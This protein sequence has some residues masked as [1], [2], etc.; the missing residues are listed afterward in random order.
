MAAPAPIG[1]V[2]PT[3]QHAGTVGRAVR[4]ALDGGGPPVRVVV[5]DDGSSDDTAAVLAA[6]DD[7]RLAVHRQANRGRGAARNRGASLCDTAALL[8]LDSD[9]ELLPGA[10]SELTGLLEEPDVELA[11]GA[12]LVERVPSDPPAV[13]PSSREV[14]GTPPRGAAGSRGPA[15]G[16]GVTVVGRPPPPDPRRP[17]RAGATLA[18]TY[19]VSAEVFWRVGGFD[20][21]LWFAENTDLFVRL[22]LDARRHGWQARHQD[23]PVVRVHAQEG[24]RRADRYGSAQASAA[25]TLLARYPRELRHEP[26]V[27]ADYWAIVGTE[28]SRRGQR[29]GA[30]AAYLRSWRDRPW[31]P[32]AAARLGSVL[33]PASLVGPARRAVHPAVRL[34]SGARR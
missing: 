2:I 18:G 4:S 14:A 23:R 32:T 1:V 12:A 27:R 17:F 21:G 16:G 29:A 6:I 33:V 3:Y 9:D 11:R 30:A 34:I 19:A 13:A 20:P 22:A 10:L 15:R 25:A 28:A 31:S 7:D 24:A 8:F 5:V 26:A